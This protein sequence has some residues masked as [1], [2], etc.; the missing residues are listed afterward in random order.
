MILKQLL[1]KKYQKTIEFL[2]DLDDEV[3]VIIKKVKEGILDVES[4]ITLPD[5]EKIMKDAVDS[6]NDLLTYCISKNSKKLIG[7]TYQV[8]NITKEVSEIKKELDEKMETQKDNIV[9]E[10][11]DILEQM[12]VGK[13]IHLD[14][15]RTGGNYKYT[16]KIGEKNY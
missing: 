7:S 11:N 16:F 3:H 6:K 13:K 4:K 15:S 9:N 10:V 12:Q 2:Q 8:N 1:K 5:F 14:I